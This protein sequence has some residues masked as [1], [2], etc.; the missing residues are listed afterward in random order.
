MIERQQDRVTISGLNGS[1]ATAFPV[2]TDMLSRGPQR[3]VRQS[4]TSLGD[5]IVGQ[6]DYK[7]QHLRNAISNGQL[8]RD[9]DEK[10]PNSAEKEDA[11]I[12]SLDFGVYLDA[13]SPAHQEATSPVPAIEFV[14]RDSQS[15]DISLASDNSRL[16]ST[17]EAREQT[18]REMLDECG[19]FVQAGPSD[20]VADLSVLGDG[21]HTMQQQHQSI[22]LSRL[23]LRGYQFPRIC[24]KC[25]AKVRSRQTCASCGHASYN[26]RGDGS[27]VRYSECVPHRRDSMVG[28][29]SQLVDAARLNAADD[30]Q[31]IFSSETP[32]SSVH[33]SRQ[34][35]TSRPN[36]P[37]GCVRQ[38]CGG[39]VGKDE[40]CNLHRQ[41]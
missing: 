39:L 6:L 4:T 20:D 33:D 22:T 19:A 25:G 1:S 30:M 23:T 11:S 5:G 26:E 37:L 13:D 32:I 40:G 8:R 28:T 2:V 31:I 17:G 3:A 14:V 7:V 27:T 9:L 24:H 36:G 29:D 35:F 18:G 16:S 12:Y 34:S 38:K 41:F 10:Y 15:T 21:Q